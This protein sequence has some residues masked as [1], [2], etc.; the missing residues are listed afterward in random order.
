MK[1]EI[2]VWKF[3][4]I[5]ISLMFFTLISNEVIGGLYGVTWATLIYSTI[6]L[7]AYE[8]KKVKK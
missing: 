7:Y 4:M 2:S 1:L 8:K 5:I 6:V 3:N